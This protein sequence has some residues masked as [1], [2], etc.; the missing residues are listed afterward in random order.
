[1]RTSP[2]YQMNALAE[3]LDRKLRELFPQPADRAEATKALRAYGSE[4]H[5]RERE[6]VQLAALKLAGADLEKLHAQMAIAKCDYRDVLAAAEYPAQLAAPC[7]RLLDA[8]Q[9]RLVEA[10]RQQYLAW[11]HAHDQP[12]A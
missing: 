4:A 8:E 10:D 12:G 1:M 5:E 9:K 2:R 7:E 3:H 6:R 11:L